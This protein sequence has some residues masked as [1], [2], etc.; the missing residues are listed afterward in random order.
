MHGKGY[1]GGH[2][3]YEDWYEANGDRDPTPQMAAL[4]LMGRVWILPDGQISKKP[5][6]PRREK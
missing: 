4:E 3:R 6:Q 2:R 5:V 1:C